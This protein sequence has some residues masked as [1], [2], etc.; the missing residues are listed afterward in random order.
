MLQEN[1]SFSPTGGTLSAEFVWNIGAGDYVEIYLHQSSGSNQALQV[2][3]P[4]ANNGF[5]MTKIG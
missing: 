2:L 1:L 3:R 5:T 4:G